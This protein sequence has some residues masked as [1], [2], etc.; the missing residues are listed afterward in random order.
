MRTAQ[1]DPVEFGLAL[2]VGGGAVLGLVLAWGSIAWRQ[3]KQRRKRGTRHSP[4]VGTILTP[5]QRERSRRR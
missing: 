5:P 3:G 2:L 4:A 1:S